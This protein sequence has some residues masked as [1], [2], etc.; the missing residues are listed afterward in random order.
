MKN[1]YVNKNKDVDGDHEVHES[2]CKHMPLA[3]NRTYLG[4]FSSCSG[5]VTEAKKTYPTADG[6]YH[7]CE[8]CHTS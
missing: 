1:Y 7:C 5:A 6:C 8:A 2:G 4:E 3:E